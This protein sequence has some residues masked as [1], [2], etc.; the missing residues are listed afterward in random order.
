MAAAV[1]VEAV[2]R[3]A[4]AR[5]K[6]RLATNAVPENGMRSLSYLGLLALLDGLP[7]VGLWLTSELALTAMLPG[8]GLQPQFAHA[9]MTVL[10]IWR[11]N[12]LVLRLVFRP[13]LAAARLCEVDD[14]AARHIYGS[15]VG[16]MFLFISFAFSLRRWRRSVRRMMPSPRRA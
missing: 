15:I 5:L 13:D 10:L 16:I 9:A 7:V 8:A 12:A 4:L 11:V 3:A 1:A 6:I 14:H 2:L